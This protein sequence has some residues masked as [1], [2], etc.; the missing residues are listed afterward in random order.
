MAAYAVAAA[1]GE[2]SAALL[3]LLSAGLSFPGPG[4]PRQL[5]HPVRQPR[6]CGADRQDSSPK[7][8]H[9]Q[10]ACVVVTQE[11]RPGDGWMLKPS[12]QAQRSQCQD[13]G[14]DAFRHAQ[15]SQR[16]CWTALHSGSCLSVS[17]VI[18]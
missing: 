6:G 1:Q 13:T 7:P 2:D 10:S 17:Q 8:L 15:G 14:R 3:G 4:A 12:E 18:R 11:G 5:A 9:H 16:E